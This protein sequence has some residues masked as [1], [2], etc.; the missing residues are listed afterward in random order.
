[1][2]VAKI[3]DGT[4]Q[5]TEKRARN[6]SKPCHEATKTYKLQEKEQAEK[7]KEYVVA[8]QNA[9]IRLAG[10]GGQE[11]LLLLAGQSDRCSKTWS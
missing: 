2:L 9:T 6:K 10:V 7:Y 5:D 3:A 1:M 4:K 8:C 11:V